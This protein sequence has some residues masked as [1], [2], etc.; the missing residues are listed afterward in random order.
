MCHLTACEAHPIRAEKLKFNLQR[1]GAKNV[2]LLIQDARK[3]DPY[4][5]FDHILLDAPCTGTGT[6]E[7]DHP[8]TYQTFSTKL[9]EH[10]ML[11]QKELLQAALRMAKPGKTI[12]YSTCSILPDE[13]EKQIEHLLKTGKVELIPIDNEWFE[14]LPTLT[15]RLKGTLLIPPTEYYE[16]FFVAQLKKK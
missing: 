12:V 8:H 2:S 5:T 14:K 7:L 10:V 9:L 3:L 13:N 16:G 6:F 11:T 15:S 4:F 1:Q